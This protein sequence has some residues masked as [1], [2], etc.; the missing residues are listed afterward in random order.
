MYYINPSTWWIS[1][2]LAA[3]LHDIPV[4]CTSDE[5]AHF[6]PPPGQTCTQY[7]G[8]FAQSAG[9]Y[10]LNP[11]AT[12]DCAYCPYSS[13]DQYLATLNIQAGQ[14]WRDFGIFLIFVFSNWFLVYF[15]IYTVRVKGW[16]FGL[17]YVF[18]GLGKVVD[19]VK[20]PFAKKQK[21]QDE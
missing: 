16:S 7:A 18:A 20:K 19:L 1:G 3:T 15:F 4:Q 14:K 6:N 9:G 8:A 5:A 13:G 10:L 12:A 2:V 11:A 17:G 21:Q